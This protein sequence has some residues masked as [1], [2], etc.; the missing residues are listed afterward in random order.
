MNVINRFHMNLTLVTALSTLCDDKD[1]LFFASKSG[2]FYY[3][4]L[5]HGRSMFI[6]RFIHFTGLKEYI[7][8]K[9]EQL[10]HDNVKQSFMSPYVAETILFYKKRDIAE[11]T[12]V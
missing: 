9:V 4:V 5:L 1:Y 8:Y 11:F 7:L 6:K 10:I 2:R 12:L 3:C